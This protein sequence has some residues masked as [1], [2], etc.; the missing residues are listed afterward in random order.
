MAAVVSV[1][2]KNTH[3]SNH[4]SMAC[5]EQGNYEYRSQKIFGQDQ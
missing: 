5:H 2:L 4:T 1:L 3:S